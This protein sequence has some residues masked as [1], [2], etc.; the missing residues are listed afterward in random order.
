MALAARLGNS[1]MLYRIGFIYVDEDNC[2]PRDI[3]QTIVWFKR[4]IAQG[5]PYAPSL[6][7]ELYMQGCG[8]SWDP[9]KGINL[10]LKSHNLGYYSAMAELGN[11]YRKM[12]VKKGLNQGVT[13]F[14]KGQELH[15]EVE[16]TG[17]F[18]P[19][20]SQYVAAAKRGSGKAASA[21]AKLQETGKA[22]SKVDQIESLGWRAISF[23]LIDP[24][25]YKDELVKNYG[26]LSGAEKNLA[27]AKI[28]GFLIQILQDGTNQRLD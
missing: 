9:I 22:P 11:A 1:E 6:L 23:S 10:Y 25:P 18:Q 28:V 8:V 4:S 27:F 3:E 12:V 24:Q 17:N 19:A 13:D 26:H 21:I 5:D 7:G 20:L 2:L 16:R 15:A 14:R